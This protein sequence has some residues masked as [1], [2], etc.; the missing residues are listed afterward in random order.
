MH[1][2]AERAFQC[3]QWVDQSAQRR[4]RSCLFQTAQIEQAVSPSRSGIELDQFVAR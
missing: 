1:T 4:L 3:R 2:P